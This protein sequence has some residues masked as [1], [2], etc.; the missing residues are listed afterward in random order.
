[1]RLC[2]LLISFSLLF[3]SCKKEIEPTEEIPD[4]ATEVLPEVFAGD[5]ND[6]M[7]LQALTPALTFNYIW[8][9]D[10]LYGQ[11]TDSIDIN[12]DGLFDFIFSLHD[13]NEDSIHLIEGMPSPFPY[14]YLEAKNGYEFCTH[15]ETYPIGLGSYNTATYVDRL[16]YSEPIDTFSNWEHSYT[17]LWHEN[18]GTGPGVPPV[19]DWYTCDTLNYI[20]IRNDSD[21]FGWIEADLT[22][23]K[24]PIIMRYAIEY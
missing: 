9:E 12:E 14:F 8:D 4:P 15:Q 18:P 11:A 22:D 7:E 3:F 1:M 23:P 10:N 20:G 17:C 5:V 16:S 6:D 24:N 2:L 19:G 13:Y 21:K